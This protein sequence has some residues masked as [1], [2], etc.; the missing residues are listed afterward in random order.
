MLGAVAGVC[1]GYTVQADRD[2]DP[3]PPLAQQAMTQAGG[4]KPPEKLSAAQD[5]RVRTDGD[6][7]KLLL[8]RP[9]GTQKADADQGWLDQYGYAEY[10]KAPDAMFEELSRGSYRRAALSVWEKGNALTEI[11]LVQF[12]D[13]K[14][15]GSR[16]FLTGQ[17]SYMGGSKW[18][19]NPGEAVPGSDT[20]RLYVYDHPQTKAGY[21][22]LY[23]SRALAARGDIVMDIWMYDS[24]P[25]PKKTAMALAE[26]Q[27]ER[28]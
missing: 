3:L 15:L 6:L 13:D 25:I 18:A 10:F 24:K 17:Q 26:R 27:L 20:G 9:A 23:T 5:R 1:T 12:R 7:R 21:L 11:H 28:L 22:P 14:E 19:G 8:P 4:G 16:D 2:P